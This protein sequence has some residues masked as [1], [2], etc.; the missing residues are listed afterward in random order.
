MKKSALINKSFLLPFLILVSTFSVT[1][2]GKGGKD[3]GGGTF[4]RALFWSTIREEI[5]PGLQSSE[6]RTLLTESERKTL[7]ANMDP[8]VTKIE[9][10]KEQLY[11]TEDGKRVPVDAVNFASPKMIQL[12]DP[13]WQLQVSSNMDIKHLI[14][15]EF[16]GV[17]K[18]SDK[19]LISSQIFPPKRLPISF[20]ANDLECEA[21]VKYIRVKDEGWYIRDMP[22][23]KPIKV[24]LSQVKR[25]NP[26]PKCSYIDPQ[27]SKCTQYAGDLQVKSAQVRIPVEFD[28]TDSSGSTYYIDG[29][30]NLLN[31]YY[32]YGWGAAASD[33]FKRPSK[34]E[35]FWKLVK[36][37]ENG[38]KQTLSVLTS[39]KS[40]T[41][42]YSD[43]T[44][45]AQDI[46]VSDFLDVLNSN[47][48]QLSLAGYSGE[49]T[50]LFHSYNVAGFLESLA[51][52]SGL[53]DPS[54][55]NKYII[56]TALKGMSGN[57][58]PFRVYTSCEL[59]PK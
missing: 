17:S 14:L 37:G 27:T 38:A 48:T 7:I 51:D 25:L 1:T 15:H 21:A 34:L 44:T 36:V 53:S 16:M 31:S 52:Q 58:L 59:I 19:N 4:S 5:I 23:G 41:D 40:S 6:N 35:M 3:G 39:S 28:K 42:D 32:G 50:S 24:S 13:S 47:G 18:I 43:R 10:V 26:K 56:E 54:K 8:A 2:F 57:A 45:L 30:I 33:T 11:V 46:P 22:P 12:F 55:R 20:A 49:V 29:V 9:I